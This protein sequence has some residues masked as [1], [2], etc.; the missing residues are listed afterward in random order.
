MSESVL[1]DVA[2]VGGGPAGLTAA[3]FAAKQGAQTILI[4]SKI[5]L[6]QKIL[7]SGGGR[8]NIL[9][10]EVDPTTYVTDSSVHT[11]R[12][13]LRSWPLDEVRA[14]LESD[15]KLKLKTDPVSGKLHVTGGGKAARHSLLELA[16]HAG[17]KIK[18]RFQVVRLGG[19]D[20]FFLT[21]PEKR[22]IRATRVILACGGLSYPQT[23][24]DGLALEILRS[25]EHQIVPPYPALTPLIG[26]RSTH[27]ILSGITMTVTVTARSETEEASCRGGFLFTHRGYS[28][29]AI[30][31]T[32]HVVARARQRR[33]QAQVF[34]SWTDRTQDE[35][36][37]LLTEGKKTI[38]GALIHEMPDRVADQLLQEISLHEG[39][40]ATLEKERR[41]QLI[42]LLT[43]YP[44]PITRNDGF[45]SAEVTGG[46]LH[47]REIDQKTMQSKRLS[48][49]YICGEMLDAFG[50]IGGTN[51]LWAFVTGRRAGEAAG[52]AS[53][54]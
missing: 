15:V 8:C 39:R 2:V 50:P 47:L 46:G 54:S 44:L 35:W 11:L 20:P 6:G 40:V 45:D 13:I 43:N 24:S 29:P 21:C 38:R 49:L 14:F 26:A 48:N 9:P 17:V 34:V 16:E 37:T 19:S 4:D 32:S 41:D 3:I 1:Y 25:R 36:R 27:R 33:E 52:K 51:F 7:L 42:R 12:N 5:D 23:G 18:R 53:V 10:T 28:G 30:L 31:N 22:T